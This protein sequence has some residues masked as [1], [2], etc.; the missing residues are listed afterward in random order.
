MQNVKMLYAGE[1]GLVVEFGSSIDEFT[2]AKVAKL[3]ELVKAAE[4]KGIV[5]VVPTYRSVLIYFNPLVLKRA[6]LVEHIE[7]LVAQIGN[8]SGSKEGTVVHIPVCYT[9]EEFAPDIAFVAEHNKIS[10]QEVIE[11]HTKPEYLVYMLGFMAGFPY[12]G[13]MSDKIIT[14][15]LKT[16]RSKIPGGSVGIADKQTGI[17]PV[18]SPGGWQLI[19]RTPVLVYNPA[20]QNPFLF[21]AGDYLKFDSIDK[22]EFDDIVAQ[23]QAGTYQPVHSKLGGGQ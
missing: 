2:N 11:L 13:G 4:K 21:K 10:V 16:P 5:E 19:G 1:Q 8:V 14:P 22:A 18:E 9:H 6:Q 17:Y 7:V 23:V 12:L 3:T 20:L 15:R